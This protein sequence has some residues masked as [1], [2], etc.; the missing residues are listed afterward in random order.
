ME[1]EEGGT[2]GRIT[3]F[4]LRASGISL[5]ASGVALSNSATV[6]TS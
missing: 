4:L 2:L 3:K 1:A 6:R 5:G